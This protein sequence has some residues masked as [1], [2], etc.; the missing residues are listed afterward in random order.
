ML[1]KTALITGASRGLGKAISDIFAKNGYN[2]IL[3][4]KESRMPPI[5]GTVSIRLYGDIRLKNTIVSLSNAAQ[6]MN[7]DVLINNAGIY[8][9]KP[10]CKIEDSEFREMLD[11]NLLAPILLT[12]SIWPIFQK[13]GHGTIVNVNSVAGR[14]VSDGEA[15]YCASKYGLRGFSDSI[16]FDAVRDN[17]H[18]TDVYPSAMKTDMMKYR[19]NWKD[20]PAPAKIAQLIFEWC[21][22]CQ[23]KG[24][25]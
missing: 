2:L 8:L 24:T 10:F 15:A 3:H 7:I 21:E 18:V 16:K 13:K 9:N 11:V 4:C 14:T 1:K 5:P 22:K 25:G 20:L 17:I 12:K 6:E 19:K 23:K